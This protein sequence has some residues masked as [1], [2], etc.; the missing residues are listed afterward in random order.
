MSHEP[1][2][3]QEEYQESYRC[4]LRDFPGYTETRELDRLHQQE[5]RRLDESGQ[6]YLDY[7]GGGLYAE[8]QISDHLELLRNEV[9]GNPHSHN[10]ASQTT[11]KLVEQAR[12]YVL[13]FFDADPDEY[14]V[15][16]T[17]NASGALRL[18]GEAYPFTKG[19]RFLLS[20]DNHNSVNGIREFARSRDAEVSYIPI[21]VPELRTNETTVMSSLER[22]D[23][24]LPNLFAYPA[25]SNFTGVQHPLQFISMAQERGWDVLLDAAAFVPTN[26]L[27]LR[28]WHPDY[29]CISFYKMF[30]YPTGIGAL[31]ARKEALQRLNRPW[32]AGGT[33]RLA[34]VREMRHHLAEDE[35]AFEDGTVNYLNIPAVE[36][37]LRYLQSVSLEVIHRRVRCLTGYLLQELFSLRHSNGKPQVRIYGPVSTTS[38]GGT[39]AFNLYDP[40]ANLID[41]R[42]IEELAAEQGISLRTGCFCNPGVNEMAENLTA[43][44]ISEGFQSR[45]TSF[46]HFLDTIEHVAGKSAGA[47]RVSFGLASNFTD[48]YRLLRF[49]KQFRDSDSDVVGG[50]TFEIDSCRVIRDGS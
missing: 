35:A 31:I 38:R 16:F 9:F 25:Q 43:E 8:S 3:H 1:I 24:T 45:D 21:E 27:D 44:E 17:P 42:R 6:V 37:G 48:A 7:T 14:T 47:V 36:T 5:Y 49:L 34:A 11:T 40:G 22:R 13:S 15:I 4:F 23:E 20:Y 28:R 10:P 50:V 18:V 32:F 41:Y 33:I 19:G 46:V 12:R 26:S 39:I 29:V 2:Q 30:G